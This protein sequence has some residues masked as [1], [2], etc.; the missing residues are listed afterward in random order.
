MDLNEAPATGA[1]PTMVSKL[2]SEHLGLSIDAA[3]SRQYRRDVG[4][5]LV[6]LACAVLGIGSIVALVAYTV[7]GA[8]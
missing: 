6:S 8:R 2:A 3:L 7:G 5:M 1:T 4:T